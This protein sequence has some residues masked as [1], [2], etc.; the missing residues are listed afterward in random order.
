MPQVSCP[1]CK[2][3]GTYSPKHEQCSAC[4]L[5]YEV[6]PVTERVTREL[7]VTATVTE[8]PSVTEERNA[9]TD[10]VTPPQHAPGTQPAA[11]HSSASHSGTSDNEALQRP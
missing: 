3:K 9:V 4:G 2:R 1:S 7:P 5:G 10:A 6:T 11:Q 8:P